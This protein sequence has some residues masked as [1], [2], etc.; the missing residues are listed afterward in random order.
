MDG[1]RS[2]VW[3]SGTLQ[4]GLANIAEQ[5]PELSKLLCSDQPDPELEELEKQL[6]ELEAW[7]DFLLLE[8]LALFCLLVWF[9]VRQKT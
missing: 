7:Y 6:A 9:I 3:S 4:N 2:G 8:C 5:N 1:L